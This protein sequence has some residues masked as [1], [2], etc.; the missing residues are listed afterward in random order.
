VANNGTEKIFLA[1]DTSYNQEL[2]LQLQPDGVSSKKNLALET[3]KK[4]ITMAEQDPLIY[5]P[6]HDSK[7]DHRLKNLVFLDTSKVRTKEEEFSNNFKS[8]PLPVPIFD[9]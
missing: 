4:I 7:S 2:L 9:K 5:L 1:G 6:S 3:Q 8:N